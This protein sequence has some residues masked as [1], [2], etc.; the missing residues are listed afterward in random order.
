M[1]TTTDFIALLKYRTAEEGG[2]LTP[3]HSGYRPQIE[4]PF[5]KMQTGCIQTFIDQDTVAPGESVTASIKIIGTEYFKGQLYENLEFNFCEGARIIGTGKIISIVNPVLQRKADNKPSILYYD[6]YEHFGMS[7]PS[8]GKLQVNTI[9]LKQ[10]FLDWNFVKTL[11]NTLFAFNRFEIQKIKTKHLFGLFTTTQA[12]KQFRILVLDSATNTWYI[13]KGYWK[14]L[15]LTHLLID[16]VYFTNAFHDGDR[17]SFPEES[18]A[19][20]RTNFR[21]VDESE[22]V[23][24]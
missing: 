13:S 14:A 5:A 10:E 3:A 16:T 8:I 24:M 4:F 17:K 23:E 7:G 12:V 19:F 9:E 18:I 1:I 15:F 21:A 6:S 22:I 2:R 20:N 11:N